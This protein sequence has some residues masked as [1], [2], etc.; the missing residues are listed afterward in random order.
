MRAFV[1]RQKKAM[2]RRK[3]RLE[4]TEIIPIRWRGVDATWRINH[5]IIF[6]A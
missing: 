6:A 2:T 1:F 3:H 5:A 4:H